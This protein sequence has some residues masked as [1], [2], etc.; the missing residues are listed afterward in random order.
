MII[1]YQFFIYKSELTEIIP[2][3][4]FSIAMVFVI[5]YISMIISLPFVFIVGNV[6]HFSH[7][8]NIISYICVG[9]IS[10][11]LSV[12]SFKNKHI[13]SCL[14]Q[15]KNKEYSYISTVLSLGIIFIYTY[16]RFS[17]IHS[18]VLAII[19]IVFILLIGILFFISTEKEVYNKYNVH[20]NNLKITSLKNEL[21]TIKEKQVE[22]ETTNNALE[23]IIHNDN[24]LIPALECT[25][26]DIL[27]DYS[28]EKASALISKLDTIF[29]ERKNALK[30]Y[31]R[32]YL[33][34]ATT[35]NIV[36]NSIINY[37]YKKS[38]DNGITFQYALF[39]DISNISNLG[40]SDDDYCTLLADL[41][42]NA[43]IATRNN[44]YDKN[45]MI[46]INAFYE[47]CN[48]SV[49]D[50]GEYFSKDVLKKIGK[51]RTTTHKKE[52]G[53]GIGLMTTFELLR[54]YSAS[55]SIDENI[56]NSEYTKC[57]SIS[58]DFKH[59]HTYN[60]NPL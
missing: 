2:I 48:F 24:K 41:I 37:M 36:V 18:I 11:F 35:D 45:I 6:S 57:V 4:L 39:G 47:K 55:F 19:V 56:N 29:S 54:K 33:L 13:R 3:T 42:E 51:K 16:F 49:Y 59:S 23:K 27:L 12:L 60:N 15:L 28:T 14:L 32:D 7:T 5:D 31:E 22:L 38:I 26:K 40:I 43:I 17:H 52:G 1:I 34:I 53:T 50:N 9:I 8:F 20:M 10:I 46:I 30:Y 21:S 25:V 58:F 44:D